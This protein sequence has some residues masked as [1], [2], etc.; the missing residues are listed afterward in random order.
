[1]ADLID[2][3]ALIAYCKDNADCEWNRQVAPESWSAA[4]EDFVDRIDEVPAVDAVEVVR[5]KD[6]K[7]KEN[8]MKQLVFW[9]RDHVLEQNV[10][11]YHKL[12]FR[13]YGEKRS[14]END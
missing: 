2:R 11:Q 1:M 9:E 14:N 8:C 10:Y 6:C 4:Y 13:S 3:A 12:D 5:C 7:H